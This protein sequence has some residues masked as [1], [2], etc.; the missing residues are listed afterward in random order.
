METVNPGCITGLTDHGRGNLMADGPP[1]NELQALVDIM[2]GRQWYFSTS[3]H[4]RA[5]RAGSQGL[6]GGAVELPNGQL[7]PAVVAFGVMGRRQY[8]WD[9]RSM[10]EASWI[11]RFAI[12]AR[13]WS[14]WERCLGLSS[15][16]AWP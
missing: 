4:P 8:P 11:D 9:S 15:A 10:L 5:K 7:G 12:S 16:S 6:R 1:S 14:S 3:D 2:W 13:S